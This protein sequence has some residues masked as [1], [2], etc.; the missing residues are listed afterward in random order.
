M[1]FDNFGN[2]YMCIGNNTYQIN[3]SKNEEIE[4]IKI[5]IPIKNKSDA[6]ICFPISVNKSFINCS[7]Q[8]IINSTSIENNTE[9]DYIDYNSIGCIGNTNDD[10]NDDG[11]DLYFDDEQFTFYSNVDIPVYNTDEDTTA[12]YETVIFKDDNIVFRS[13]LN[14]QPI[15]RLFIDINANQM[16]LKSIGAVPKK[17]DIKVNVLDYVSALT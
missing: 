10:D 11:N 3:I 17:F 7:I 9:S 2:L 8:D 13:K 6:S 16:C 4:Y 14:T 5:I 12:L 15:Y 1:Y